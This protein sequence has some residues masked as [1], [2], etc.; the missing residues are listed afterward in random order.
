MVD[1]PRVIEVSNGVFAYIQP[2][3]TWWINNAGF[4]TGLRSTLVV[5][6][7]ATESR[8][9]AFRAAVEQ[10][11]AQ[12]VTTVVNTHH[13]GD[14]THGN[15]VFRPAPVAAHERCREMLLAFGLPD[16]GDVFDI[17]WG[18]L[19]LEPPTI[20]FPD[21]LD[22]WVDDRRVELHYIGGPAHTTNDVVVWLPDEKVLFSGDLV[23][24]GGTPFVVM[25]SIAG[26]MASLSRLRDFGAE[27]IVPGHG[28]VCTPAVL[29]DLLAYFTFL[30]DTA[31]EGRRAGL[32]PLEAA[33]AA[34]LGAFAELTDPE[35]LVGNLHR[36]YAEL[37][38]AAPGAPIDLKAAIADMVTY[39]GGKP[40]RCHV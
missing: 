24:N 8:A 1:P 40:L 29:D 11:T 6:T 14:H 34:D 25:G 3:G 13:H 23:F 36:A 4:V 18:Q 38:G 26:S 22:L 10:V 16:W 33:R 20:T 17:D 12:P 15:F 37:D 32:G 35:R 19:E 30:G 31:A 7:C 21:R 2:D 5:D 9:R 27:V 39:A 28:E